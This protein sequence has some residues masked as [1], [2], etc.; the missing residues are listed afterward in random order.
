MSIQSISSTISRLNKELSDITHRMS[1]EQTKASS[2]TAKII[3]LQ[4]SITKT[5]TASTLK[6][7][8]SEI[9][10]KEQE[11]A[12]IQKKLS[13]LQKKKTDIQNKL[14]KEN[15]NLAKA[16]ALERKKLDALAK[17]QQK[18]EIEHQKKLKREIE[19][20]KASTQHIT[21]ATASPYLDVTPEPE[22]D[23]FISHASEDKDDFVRPLAETLQGLGL[24]VWYDE[25]SMRVGDSLRRKIDSGLRNSRYG[26]VVLS[27][28]FIKKEWTNYELD[29]LVAREMN[30]HKMI[31]PIWHKITKTDVMNYSPN[32]ADKI[33]LNTSFSTIEEI[34]HQLADVVLD[35]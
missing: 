8:L 10:R 34:A 28:D 22:Y 24:K 29:A 16:E 20:I 14:L 35:K 18:E 2:V 1:L 21:G 31:L 32:L 30:G 9:S 33:A 6:T 17:K 3:Q 11:N 12:Q 4:T 23:L 19:S 27:A 25:F 15:Q 7:K 26:T 5:T 13:D